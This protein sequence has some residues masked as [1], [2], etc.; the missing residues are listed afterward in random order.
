MFNRGQ[1]VILFI[2]GLSA[3]M[4]VFAVWSQY[5]Q[6][7]RCMGFWGSETANLIRH[8]PNVEFIVFN[9]NDSAPAENDD[10]VRIG[11][12]TWPVERRIDLSTAPGFVH[13]RHALIIDSGY[14][15]K[16]YGGHP[17]PNSEETGNPSPE[18][19]AKWRYALRFSDGDRVAVIRFDFSNTPHVRNENGAELELKPEL[20]DAEKKYLF[21]QIDR[22]D[23]MRRFQRK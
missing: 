1:L 14:V 2:F 4:G 19:I 12:G 20:A 21:Q 15:W 16:G 23:A 3:A 7:R 10:V 8:A 9:A 11:L 17:E 13:A 5:Q 22:D 18:K 6:G